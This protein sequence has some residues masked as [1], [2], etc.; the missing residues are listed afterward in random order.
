MAEEERR[1][2][3][4]VIEV[5]SAPG[6]FEIPASFVLPGRLRPLP[7][8][9]IHIPLIDLAGLND[10]DRRSDVQNQI[11][12]ACCDWGFFQALNH[13]VS[14]DVLHDFRARLHDFFAM[15]TSA[16]RALGL[17]IGDTGQGYGAGFVDPTSGTTEWK[18][19][20]IFLTHPPTDRDYSKYPPSLRYPCLFLGKLI[21]TGELV[22]FRVIEHWRK[23]LLVPT[24]RIET[25]FTISPLIDVCILIHEFSC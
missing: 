13:G 22:G 17:V 15:P 25:A 9:S 10:A 7:A 4:G 21:I 3:E 18:D 8:P 14:L 11:H 16:K 6:V 19:F 20:L 5:I 24:F 23:S 1:S 2:V 12:R